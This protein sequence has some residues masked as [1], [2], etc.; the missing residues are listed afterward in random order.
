VKE[1]ELFDHVVLNKV[2]H[3]LFAYLLNMKVGLWKRKDGQL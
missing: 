1:L 3:R 2:I